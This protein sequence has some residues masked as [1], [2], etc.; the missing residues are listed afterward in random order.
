MASLKLTLC[1]YNFGRIMLQPRFELVKR[2]LF[3]ANFIFAGNSFSD[4]IRGQMIFHC[5]YCEQAPD[6]ALTLYSPRKSWP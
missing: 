5:L 2:Y 1:N 3:G 6:S 4:I